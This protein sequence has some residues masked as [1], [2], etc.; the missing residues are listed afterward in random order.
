MSKLEKVHAKVRPNLVALPDFA[1]ILIVDDQRFDRTRLQR[2]ISALEFENHVVEADCLETMGTM[3]EADKFDLILLDY[4]LPDDNGLQALDSVQLAAKNKNAAT[5]MIAGDGQNE[6]AI[7]A[8]KRGCSDYVTKDDLTPESF[9]R[10]TINA[11]QK[12][13]LSIGMEA[14]DLKRQQIEAV[15]QRFSTECAQEI[16]PVVSRMMR[17]V[18]DLRDVTN[19]TPEAAADRHNRIEQSC[20]RLWDFLN[21]LED[22]EGKD[23]TPA[24]HLADDK[25]LEAPDGMSSVDGY[26]EP[27]VTAPEAQHSEIGSK[28]VPERVVSATQ[29]RSFWRSEK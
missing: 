6:I 15:L 17:Q 11:L 1:S 26:Y 5:I 29:K 16:K 27:R 12:S 22:Y 13:R 24:S 7:E 20:M 2:L 18:R 3:L 23:I 21:D 9:R 8:L 25:W 19:V 10:A 4:N 28:V 14:Q